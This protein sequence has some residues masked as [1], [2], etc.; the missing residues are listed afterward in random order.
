MAQNLTRVHMGHMHIESMFSECQ[1][2]VFFYLIQNKIEIY[3]W[4]EP[5]SAVRTN[6]PYKVIY[7]YIFNYSLLYRLY[8]C[9]D[10]VLHL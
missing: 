4:C 10:N 9:K 6:G 8:D 2:S 5:G 3:K 1:R 7:H